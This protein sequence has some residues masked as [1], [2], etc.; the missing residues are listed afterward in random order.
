MRD[1]VLQLLAELAR[2]QVLIVVTHEPELFKSWACQRHQLQ[3]GEL[4][5]MSTLP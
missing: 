1:D 4:M 2:E 5:P 3:N